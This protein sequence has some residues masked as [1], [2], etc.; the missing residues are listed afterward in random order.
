MPVKRSEVLSTRRGRILQIIVGDYIEHAAPVGSEHVVRHHDL[1][2][3]S[4]TIRNDMAVLEDEGYIAQPHTSAGRIPSDKGYRYFIEVLMEPVELP[5]DVQQQISAELHQEGDLGEWT[6]VA[7]DALSQLA[8][9]MG[10]I[11]MA[12][13]TS[14]RFK[15]VELVSVQ[16]MVALLILVLQEGRVRQQML[17][18]DT[19]VTQDALSALSHRLSASLAGMGAI[20]LQQHAEAATGLE[21]QV[22]RAAARLMEAEDAP[23]SDDVHYGGLRALMQEPEFGSGQRLRTLMEVVEDREFLL[24]L[25]RRVSGGEAMQVVIG[26]ENPEETLREFSIIAA[27]YGLPGQMA[28]TIAVMGPTRMRYGQ[29]LAA[30]QYLARSMTDLMAQHYR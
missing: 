25:L 29:A 22:L 10:L 21:E 4:A 8:R 26:G 19:P 2:V 17:H 14:A 11:T 23:R 6:K 18:L 1:G 16:D 24:G 13:A 20:Q 5:A 7:T 30:V 27:P 9:T 12:R 28:G 15:H 3:S